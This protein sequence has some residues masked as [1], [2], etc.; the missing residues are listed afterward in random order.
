MFDVVAH[1]CA[2]TDV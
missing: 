2:G 1:R